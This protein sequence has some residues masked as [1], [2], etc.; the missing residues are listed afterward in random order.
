MTRVAFY[1]SGFIGGGHLALAE[2]IQRGLTRSG[3][4]LKLK[5]FYAELGLTPPAGLSFELTTLSTLPEELRQAES[6][7]ASETARA[8]RDFAP[9]VLLV[10]LAFRDLRHLLPLPNCE[11]WLLLRWIPRKLL[12]GPFNKTFDP[13]QYERVIGTEPGLP[14]EV[15]FQ[16]EPL[17]VCNR[18]ECMPEGSLL[19]RLGV[20]A[21]KALSLIAHTGK[22]SEVAG[23]EQL[24]REAF[25]QHFVARATLHDEAALF[26]LAPWL[27]DADRIVGG[28]GY[29]LYWETRWLGLAA[30]SELR[31]FSRGIDD[32]TPRMRHGQSYHMR[33]NGADQLAALLV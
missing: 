1:T 6:A 18:D 7:Q 32:Q 2:A 29:G 11:A 24:E 14:F 4:S 8:L 23:L 30:R 20:P 16:L 21:G 28:A 15:P 19:E 10:D 22:E 5:V 9:D 26:P 12:Y 17:V 13:S 31:P 27:P 25:P 33:E 3:S